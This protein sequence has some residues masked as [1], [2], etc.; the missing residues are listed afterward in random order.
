MSNGFWQG[1]IPLG[2]VTLIEGGRGSRQNRFVALDIAA[3]V[4][5]A[6]DWPDGMPCSDSSV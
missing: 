4:S 2:K 5:R 6:M 1:K 3:R